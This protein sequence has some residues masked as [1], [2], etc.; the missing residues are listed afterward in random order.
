MPRLAGALSVDSSWPGGNH[1]GRRG[2]PATQERHLTSHCPEESGR[3][4]GDRLGNP[5]GHQHPHTRLCR[6]RGGVWN[7][8]QRDRVRKQPT[9][10]SRRAVLAAVQSR[11]QRVRLP[12]EQRLLLRVHQRSGLRPIRPGIRVH[13]ELH[14]WTNG[15]RGPVR[16][17]RSDSSRRQEIRGV[18]DPAAVWRCGLASLDPCDGSRSSPSSCCSSR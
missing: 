7:A 9:V 4:S 10:R 15:M 5:R 1:D 16:L 18:G 14:L 8:M 13:A 12:G 2:E 11:W 3:R 17:L 6:L